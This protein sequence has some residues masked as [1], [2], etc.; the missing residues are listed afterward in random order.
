MSFG[1]KF[2]LAYQ[3]GT[4]WYVVAYDHNL[5]TDKDT[6]IALD[7]NDSSVT[8]LSSYL[9]RV[10]RTVESYRNHEVKKLIFRSRKKAEEK[11][12]EIKPMFTKWDVGNVQ[13]HTESEVLGNDGD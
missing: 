1:K 10:S 12:E 11:L 5:A 4:H 13:V 8:S 6:M 7:V 9:D 3:R 2:C